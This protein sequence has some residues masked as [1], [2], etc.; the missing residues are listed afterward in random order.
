MLLSLGGVP[1]I[2]DTSHDFVAGIFLKETE[3][4]R[5]FKGSDID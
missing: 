3:L 1:A 5:C 2:H 4:L